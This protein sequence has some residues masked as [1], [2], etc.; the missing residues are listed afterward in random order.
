MEHQA[1]E[2]SD[3]MLFNHQT[4]GCGCAADNGP[5]AYA[6]GVYRAALA[7]TNFRTAYWSGCRLQMTL[8][9]IPVDGDIGAEM[10]P[11]TDQILR[12]EA[13]QAEVRVGPCR[14]E[15]T[16]TARLCAGDAVFV[17][18]GTWHNVFNAGACPLKLTS[19]YAPPNHPRG[20]VHRAKAD[21]D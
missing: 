3:F 7:N 4:E 10:H 15:M 21:A 9:H 6:G 18:G 12:V 14:E 11:D 5:E 17:P 13:G 2:R 1:S 20:T 8:M 16:S 19:L